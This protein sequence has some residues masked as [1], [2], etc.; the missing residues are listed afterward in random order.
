[1]CHLEFYRHKDLLYLSL[2]RLLTLR[3]SKK[4]SKNLTNLIVSDMDVS[5]IFSMAFATLLLNTW[6][7]ENKYHS[8]IIITKIKLTWAARSTLIRENEVKNT[9]TALTFVSKHSPVVSVYLPWFAW[10]KCCQLISFPLIWMAHNYTWT[11]TCSYWY[12]Q[13]NTCI[14]ITVQD[15]TAY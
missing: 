1:M 4:R 6:E 7:I 9:W 11:H 15:N 5:P 14:Y 3:Q 12:W 2:E 13:H 10:T 8:G